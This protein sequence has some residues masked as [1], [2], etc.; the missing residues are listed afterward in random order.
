MV[1]SSRSLFSPLL[2]HLQ[3]HLELPIAL[4]GDIPFFL[5]SLVRSLPILHHLELGGVFT[6][7]LTTS[8]LIPRIAVFSYLI[9]I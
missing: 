9:S 7:Q 5:S 4:K 1:F 6:L 8:F 2:H 3:R